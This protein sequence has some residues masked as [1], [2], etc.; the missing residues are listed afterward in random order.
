MVVRVV[1]LPRPLVWMVVARLGFWE[2]EVGFEVDFVVDFDFVVDVGGW[3]PMMEARGSE[4]ESEWEEE[5]D[6]D[7]DDDDDEGMRDFAGDVVEDDDRG[8][9]LDLDW[10][11]M[12]LLLLVMLVILVSLLLGFDVLD[13]AGVT[14]GECDRLR[15]R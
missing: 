5:E 15:L 4:S 8:S 1:F 12:I 7:D 6:E 3:G 14:L 2:V 11:V 10:L 13:R 9:L